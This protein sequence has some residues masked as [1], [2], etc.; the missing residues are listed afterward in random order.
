VLGDIPGGEALTALKR[1]AGR[2]LDYTVKVSVN[3]ALARHGDADALQFVDQLSSGLVGPR[4]VEARLVLALAGSPYGADPHR[5]LETTMTPERARI[6]LLVSQKQPDL[7]R[8]ALRGMI[9]EPAAPM[10]EAGL[11]AAGQLA[12]GFERVVY[13]RLEDPEPSVRLAAIEAILQTIGG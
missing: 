3:L 2:D 1:L 5:I 12:M 6:A 13:G 9:A 4:A 7:A 11:R 10:R 8:T